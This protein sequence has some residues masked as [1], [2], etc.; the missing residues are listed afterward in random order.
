MLHRPA[1]LA[2]LLL[3]MPVGGLA[4]AGPHPVAAPAAD[5]RSGLWVGPIHLCRDTV[6]D[7]AVSD[8]EEGPLPSLVVTLRPELRAELQRET[9]RRVASTMPI[10]L[11]GK[12]IS[13]PMVH[14]PITGGVLALSGTSAQETDAIQAAIRGPC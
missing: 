6:S 8:A 12:L 11:D 2:L 4:H 3:A 9:E 13:E 1:L 5:E 7:S 14:E 10:R